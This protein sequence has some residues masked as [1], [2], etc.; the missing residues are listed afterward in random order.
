MNIHCHIT[1]PGTYPLPPGPPSEHETLRDL[2][3]NILRVALKV[4]DYVIM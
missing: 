1:L 3:H 4:H 2:T